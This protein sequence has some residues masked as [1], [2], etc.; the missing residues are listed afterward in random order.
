MTHD[1]YIFGSAVRGEVS[2]TSDIDVLVIPFGNCQDQYP[3]SWSVYSAETIES[4]FRAGRL[5]AWHLYLEAR[6][7]YSSGLIS[8]LTGLGTPASYS[9][10]ALDIDDLDEMLGNLL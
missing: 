7:I 4:Y 1:L 5:F 6:C 3:S 10:A 2:S 9:S 8:Y